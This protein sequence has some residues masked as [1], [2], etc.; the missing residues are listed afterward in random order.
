MRFLLVVVFLLQFFGP[1]CGQNIDS[2]A[3]EVDSS[4][5][6]IQEVTQQF[7]SL[8]NSKNLDEFLRPVEERDERLKTQT[9]IYISL[10]VAFLGILIYGLA[11]RRKKN[12]ISA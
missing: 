4:D 10:G 7:D 6:R 9:I 5:H 8:Q 3:H 11:R 12:N 2:I 1:A